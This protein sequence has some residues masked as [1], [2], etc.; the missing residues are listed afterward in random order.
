MIWKFGLQT[1]SNQIEHKKRAISSI[2]RAYY[3]F[4]L[5]FRASLNAKSGRFSTQPWS[6]WFCMDSRNAF[7]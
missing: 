7:K 4:I 6:M 1:F 2:A 5:A 3:V